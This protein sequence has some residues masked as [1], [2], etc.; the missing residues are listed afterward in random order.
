MVLDRIEVINPK[1]CA[2]EINFF[3]IPSSRKPKP[4]DIMDLKTRV[5]IRKVTI[6]TNNMMAFI[7][8]IILRTCLNQKL[9]DTFEK[10]DNLK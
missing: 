6:M 4:L 2:T 8:S 7:S 9:A 5:S 3:L 10:P 1:I